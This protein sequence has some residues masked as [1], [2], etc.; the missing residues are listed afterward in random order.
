MDPQAPDCPEAFE[1]RL[2]VPD[3]ACLCDF[4]S[5]EAWLQ[6][7]CAKDL[8]NLLDDDGE[9]VTTDAGDRLAWDSLLQEP[10]ELRQQGLPG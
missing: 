5:Q 3:E 9:H 2:G 8:A 6:A 4:Q 7:T 1:G 10:C